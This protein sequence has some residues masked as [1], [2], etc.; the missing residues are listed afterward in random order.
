MPMRQ[1]D[2]FWFWLP[3]FASWLLMSAEGPII[4]AAINRLPNEVVMLAAQGLVLSLSVTIESPIINI[5]ATTTA[6]AKDRPAYVLI[7]RFVWHWNAALT[8]V[9]FLVAYT[10]LFDVIVI[11]WMSVPLEVAEWVRVG[12]RI[13]VPWSA[14]I[15][16]RR[17]CQGLL[18]RY[19]QTR[20]VAWGTLVRLATSGGSAIALALWSGW[21]GVTIGA[22]ALV[23]G[24]VAEAI[25][26]TIAARPVIRQEFGPGSLRGEEKPLTYR[27]LFWFHLPLAGTSLLILLV[28]PMVAFSLARLDH[29]TQSLA[30]WP[31]VFQLML[32]SRSAAF[33]LPEVVIALTRG[34]ATLQPMRRFAFNLVIVNTL[35]V[36]LLIF[37][38]LIQVYLFGIQ[39]T[40]P[41]V[42]RVAQQGLVLFVLWPAL[43]VITTWLRGLLIS[44]RATTAVNA[45]MGIN[46]LVTATLLFLGVS[47]R[48]D[49]IFAA[50]LAL[51]GA[52]LA[53]I[54]VLWWGAQGRLRRITDRRLDSATPAQV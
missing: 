40:T 47:L 49:S 51:N 33:A 2:I 35:I 38:P 27:D 4:S 20:K 11:G 22:T 42:G 31:L 8:A 26:A 5:L 39:D 45:A 9:A 24:V 36:A 28:Q 41:E 52:S 48:L 43:T 7:R 37:T 30:A 13:M 19:G 21:P 3:L 23:A 1:R 16:W 10:G 32:I 53:E 18:I 50:A 25:Y 34:P 6:L 46:L 44:T 12:L 29:P 54:G 17:F 14:A 15:G